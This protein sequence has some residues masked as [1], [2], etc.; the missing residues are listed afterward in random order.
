MKHREE[1]PPDQGGSSGRPQSYH[2]FVDRHH[3]DDYRKK[4]IQALRHA[5]RAKENR[6]VVGMPDVGMSNLIRFLVTGKDLGERRVTFTYVDCNALA[7]C[8]DSEVLFAEIARQFQEQYPGTKVEH[9]V[10]GYE[11]LKRIVL[12]IEGYPLDRL[13]VTLNKTDRM[14]ATTGTAFYR[15]LKALTDLNKRVCYIFTAGLPMSEGIDPEGLLFAGRNLI[16]GRFN[17]RD[18]AGAVTEEAQRLGTEFDSDAQKQLARFTGRHAGLLRAIASAAVEEKI[19]WSGSKTVLKRL[20]RRADVLSRCRKIWQALNPSQQTALQAI[21]N[22]QPTSASENILIRLQDFGL[23]DK[24]KGTYRLFSPIFEGFLVTQ[25]TSVKP[26]ECVRI[27]KPTTK[28]LDCGQEIVVAASVYK[29]DNKI[30]VPPNELRLIA[31]LIREQRVYRKEEIAV[32]VYCE[33]HKDYESGQPIAP[34]YR[35]DD[36][37]RRVRKRLGDS[38]YIKTHYGQGYELVNC[39]QN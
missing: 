11:Q 14:L 33:E 32:Y 4:E 1:V 22:K 13:V 2:R 17:E 36:L 37:V 6:L 23:I 19:K 28:S 21:A 9:E 27:D 12:Q 15:K 16:V 26:L 25:E 5:I 29:G 24:Y 8:L 7:D 35:I 3:P 39:S 20:L 38:R 31:C 10:D 34:D 18:F 30:D